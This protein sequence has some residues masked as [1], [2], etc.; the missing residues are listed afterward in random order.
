MRFLCD[1]MLKGLARWLRAAGYDVV[2]EPDRTDD[3]LLL[4]RAQKEGRILL[5]RDRRLAE[6]QAEACVVL[7]E[8]RNLEACFSELRDKLDVDWL[9]MPFSRC[10]VCNTP[11]LE[12]DR[13]RWNEVPKYSRE[14][15]TRLLYCPTCNQLFWDGSHVKRMYERLQTAAH[16]HGAVQRKPPRY[17]PRGQ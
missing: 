7:L 2:V 8:C 5:T 10:L 15:A 13:D 16:Q 14:Q 4:E 11:L 12:A 9:Y 3:R 17:L 6:T 1:E